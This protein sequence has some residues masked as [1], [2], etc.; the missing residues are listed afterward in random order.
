M[1]ELIIELFSE[2]IPPNLQINARNQ[3]KKIISDEL[4]SVNL[5][6]K[7]F[8]IYSTPTRL[9]IFISG[10]SNKIKILPS[11]VKGPKLGVSQ[12]VAQNFARSKNV[13]VEDLYE[14]KLEKGTF[15]FAKLKGTEINTE[16]EL[17]K[18][19]PKSLNQ[20]SW[21]KSMKWSNYDLNW[22]RPL[23]SILSIFNKKHLKIKYS[24]LDSVDFTLIENDTE[25]KKKKVRNF[26][27]YFKFLKQNDIILDQNERIKV[28]SE[29]IKLIS[30][31]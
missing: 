4:S 24:H 21:K 13:S 8:I 22:G 6:Y 11:E 29:K 9:T 27:E 20:I 28:I 1:S 26:Q 5:P 25:I 19:I 15:Y 17:I 30:K 16:N 7:D 10:L 2:E 14:K 31:S 3:L 18:I 12:E 23:R